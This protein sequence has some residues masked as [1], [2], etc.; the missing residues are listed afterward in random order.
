MTFGILGKKL[1]MTQIFDK[2]G[3]MIPVTVI[4]AGP[5]YILQIKS[6]EKDGY[7]A[8]Q[9]GFDK[10]PKRKANKPEQGRFDKASVEP[11][12]FI[13]EI[14]VHDDD[15]KQFSV[16]QALTVDV[17][18]TG[19]RVDVTGVSKGRGFQGAIKRFGITRGPMSH[20][21]MYHRRPGSSGQSST[22][23]HVFKG[24][25]M[26]G[27]LGNERCTILN[28]KV[29]RTDKDRNILML[30]GSVPGAMNGYLLVRKSVRAKHQ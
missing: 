2:D 4:E 5:C 27:H 19:E 28:L 13:K 26:P 22:P 23:S 24:K 21:S 25:V 20:G 10:K 16:G 3:K 7:S 18:K 9:I 8:I 29:E 12:R 17:F 15:L 6:R 1:G 11:V 14:K 30:R